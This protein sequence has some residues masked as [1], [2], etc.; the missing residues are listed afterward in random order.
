[1]KSVRQ[2][3]R[4]RVFPKITRAPHAVLW[5]LARLVITQDTLLWGKWAVH[6]QSAMGRCVLSQKSVGVSL[7][8]FD[9]VF[10]R[11][12]S[13][14]VG[15]DAFEGARH[16]RQCNR[17]RREASHAGAETERD[18]RTYDCGWR[19]DALINQR[20]TQQRPFLN[21]TKN[22]EEMCTDATK[23]L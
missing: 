1:M 13:D 4:V 7:E 8:P 6:I 17:G 19:M 21:I 10:Q 16:W 12:H 9:G 2:K 18:R 14:R 5:R 23:K 3:E 15:G 22:K 20:K 11:W